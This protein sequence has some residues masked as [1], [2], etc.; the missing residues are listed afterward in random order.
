MRKINSVTTVIAGGFI[1]LLLL[2]IIQ[3]LNFLSKDIEITYKENE[4]LIWFIGIIVGV[5]IGVMTTVNSIVQQEINQY[6][7]ENERKNL[8]ITNQND[9]I[10]VNQESYI[11][12]I[13]ILNDEIIQNN[14]NDLKALSGIQDQNLKIEKLLQRIEKGEKDIRKINGVDRRLASIEKLIKLHDQDIVKMKKKA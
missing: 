6:A 7:T 11:A 12:E 9:K 10:I 13:R 14:K 5:A 4:G 1:I 3:P 8:I 2:I